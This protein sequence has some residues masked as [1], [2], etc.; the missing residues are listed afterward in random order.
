MKEINWEFTT[1]NI[2]S[3]PLPVFTVLCSESDVYVYKD[4]QESETGLKLI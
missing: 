1:N 2:T 3:S 4:K